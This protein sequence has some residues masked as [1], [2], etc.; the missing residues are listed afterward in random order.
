MAVFKEKDERRPEWEIPSGVY[1]VSLKSGERVN[2]YAAAW[3]VR[4]SEVPVI[5]QTAVW[6]ENYSYELAQDC[7]HFVVHIL[8]KGQQD[9]ALHFGRQSGRDIDKL[10]GIKHH[11]GASGV[12]I[13]DECLAFLECEVI[14]R[15]RFGDHIVLVGAPVSSAINHKGDALIY[16]YKDF[17]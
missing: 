3:I 16:N 15:K 8:E 1:V 10:E 5:I 13:L 17:Q 2:A 12:P 4:V 11:P 6:E 7:T 14:F 9:V